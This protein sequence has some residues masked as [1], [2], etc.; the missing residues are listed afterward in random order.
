MAIRNMSDRADLQASGAPL[1]MNVYL[2]TTSRRVNVKT[3]AWRIAVAL[4]LFITTNAYAVNVWKFGM[5]V[6][7]VQSLAD[8]SFIIYGPSGADPACPENGT[9]F[10]VEPNQN[11]Q[12]AAGIKSMLALVLTAFSTNKTV[13][14]LYDN[15]GHCNVNSLKVNP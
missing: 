14:F 4:F 5:P 8:G 6:S 11:G 13:T 10:Y 12:T 9:L 15:V 2:L 1:N 3:N 7:G